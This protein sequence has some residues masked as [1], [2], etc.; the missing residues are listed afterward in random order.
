MNCEVYEKYELG[1]TDEQTFEKHAKRCQ[2]CQ[3]LLQQDETLMSLAKGLNQPVRAPL[4]WAK[5][6]NRLRSEKQRQRRIGLTKLAQ[7][8]HPLLRLA[9]AVILAVTVGVGGY[10]MLKTEGQ[11]SGLLAGS[12]LERVE[13]LEREY[14]QA[15]RELE[16]EATPHMAQLDM[17]LMLLYRDRLETIDAQIE[18]CQ[19][20]LET[21]PANAHIRRYLLTA[22]QDK[23]ET[24]VEIVRQQSDVL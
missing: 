7:R 2:T 19:E 21:N 22:L 23:K 9:A 4:L 16:K 3:H 11:E 12:A 10:F 1:K 18:R 5:I 15:I 6:E 8:S 24:L 17:E 20:A 13:K 14:V